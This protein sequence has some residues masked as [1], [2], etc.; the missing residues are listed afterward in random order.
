MKNI[1]E[2]SERIRLTAAKLPYDYEHIF[3]DNNSTDGTVDKLRIL[4]ANDKKLKLY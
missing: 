2:L 1:D 4:A 3:I